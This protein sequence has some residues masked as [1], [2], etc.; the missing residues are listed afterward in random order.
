MICCL[1]YRFPLC[2][3][4]P[5][6]PGRPL[7][8]LE[9]TAIVLGCIVGT[10]VLCCVLGTLIDCFLHVY[11]Y[12]CSC[13]HKAYNHPSEVI[14]LRAQNLAADPALLV[15]RAIPPSYSTILVSCEPSSQILGG[16][17]EGDEEAGGGAGAGVRENSVFSALLTATP[18]GLARPIPDVLRRRLE[19]QFNDTGTTTRDLQPTKD[20]STQTVGSSESLAISLS[21]DDCKSYESIRSVTSAMTKLVRLPP[22]YSSIFRSDSLAFSADSL[23]SREQSQA[24]SNSSGRSRHS[25]SSSRGSSYCRAHGHRGKQRSHTVHDIYLPE[26]NQEPESRLGECRGGRDRN[27]FQYARTQT[28]QVSRTSYG[29]GVAQA[30]VSNSWTMAISQDSEAGEMVENRS[31]AHYENVEPGGP[32]EPLV[33]ILPPLSAPPALPS[34]PPLLGRSDSATSP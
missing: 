19:L 16:R 6:G 27:S 26:P 33:T 7:S 18:T 32:L 31:W 9:I 5:G 11:K 15:V 10:V 28:Q 24:S 8:T 17:E 20:M 22:S 23:G 2:H 30:M 34:R 14:A 25:S 13:L 29:H 4:S 3:L 12:W 21:S 1:S